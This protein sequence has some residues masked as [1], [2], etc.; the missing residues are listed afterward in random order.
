MSFLTLHKESEPESGLEFIV[1]VPG[2]L[3]MDVL[4]YTQS[5]ESSVMACS[6][7]LPIFLPATLVIIYFYYKQPQLCAGPAAFKTE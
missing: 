1:S 3:M 7:S 2:P 5:A 6:W 4:I